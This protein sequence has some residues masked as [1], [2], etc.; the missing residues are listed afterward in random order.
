MSETLDF[1]TP[2]YLSG[3]LLAHHQNLIHVVAQGESLPSELIL[4]LK[5]PDLC[6]ALAF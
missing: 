2:D 3:E 5:R 4:R 1:E 6:I